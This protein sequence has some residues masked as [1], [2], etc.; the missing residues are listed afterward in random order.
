M[1][2]ATATDTAP[3]SAITVAVPAA[4]AGPTGRR[5]VLPRARGFAAAALV[6]ALSIPVTGAGSAIGAP[7]APSLAST[8][9]A[10]DALTTPVSVGKLHV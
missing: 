4:V 9:A 5:L 2:T 1:T 6:A 7:H 10:T 8:V 3:A